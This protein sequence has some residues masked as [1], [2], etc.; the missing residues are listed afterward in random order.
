MWLE[1]WGQETE[2]KGERQKCQS[3]GES[4]CVPGNFFVLLHRTWDVAEV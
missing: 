3:R 2:E 1:G 4:E